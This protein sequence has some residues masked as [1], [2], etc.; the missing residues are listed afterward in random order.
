MEFEYS[1]PSVISNLVGILAVVA[2]IL[3][4]TFARFLLSVIFLSAAV[5]NAFTAVK[6]P[7]IYI[8]YA[9][10]TTNHLYQSIIVGPF[11][12]QV[13][14]WVLSIAVCQFFIAVLTCYQGMLMKAAMVG[15]IFFLIAI[16]PLGIGS[17]FP[18]TLIMAMAFIILLLK[19]I[20]YNIYELI[21]QR[22]N[23]SKL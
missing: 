5:V 2:A 19:K 23:F 11:S 7:D 6:N 12:Q 20:N 1:L 8:G 14:A 3:W 18:S 21:R 15:G 22:L 10:L 16:A 13:R 4:P 9:E 17:A